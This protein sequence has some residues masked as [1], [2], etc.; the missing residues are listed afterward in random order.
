MYVGTYSIKMKTFPFYLFL[1][2]SSLI[3][4]EDLLLKCTGLSH[5]ELVGASGSK[6]EKQNRDYTIQN[7][8]LLDLNEV[9]CELNQEEIV[10]E[11]NFLNIRHFRFNLQTKKITDNISGNKGFGH[12]IENFEGSC[13]Q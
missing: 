7:N 2:F 6:E 1:L 11:S 12:Y 3:N 4:A 13:I 9:P 8:T 10:C 5:F